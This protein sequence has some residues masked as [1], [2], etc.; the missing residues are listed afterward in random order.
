MLR[1]GLFFI[2]AVFNLSLFSQAFQIDTFKQSAAFKK[3]DLKIVNHIQVVGN[4]TTKESIVLRELEFNLG[5]SLSNEELAA[6]INQSKKNLLNTSLFNFAK[7]NAAL[8]DSVHVAIIIQLTERWYIFPLPILELDDNNFNTWWETKDLSRINYGMH[9]TH[10]NFRGRKEKLILTAKYGFTERYRMRYEIP[11]L[12][13]SQKLG[14]NID[15]SYNRRDEIAYNSLENKRLQFKDPDG[16]AY[17][18]L[19]NSL[20]LTYRNKIFNTHSFSANFSHNSISDSVVRLNENFLL[21]NQNRLDY[22]RLSY[23]FTSDKRDSRNYPLKGSFWKASITQNGLGIFSNLN[24]LN[25][26]V[27]AKKFIELRPRVYLAGSVRA[28]LT[29]N[30]NQPYFLRNGLGYSSFGIRSYEYY[31]IDGQNIGL[32]KLQ[33][34]YQVVKPKSMNLTGI[35]ERFGKFHYAFYLGIFSDFAY[36]EDQIGYPENRLANELQFG[37]GIGLDFVSYYD[38]VLRAE[39]SFNKFGESGLFLHFVAPI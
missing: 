18:N 6:A 14:L 11:Y 37:S 24:L 5:D 9:L 3:V 26:N 36:V 29:P 30:N 15:L 31:V 1:Y 35:S 32:G 23:Q 38:I 21:K 16:D 17:R 20:T 27:E 33:L 10:Y 2:F 4:K 7:I 22:I 13:A 25:L 39:Y 19:S 12:T 28:L 34:R 8:M